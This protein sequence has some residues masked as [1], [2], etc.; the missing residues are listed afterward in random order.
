MI[1]T[2]VGADLSQ[3]SMKEFP[4]FRL[5][6]VNQCLWRHS[7]GADEQRILLTPKAF[8]MLRYL[9]EHAGRPVT[10]DELL[11]ALWPDTF[12]QPEVLKSHIRDIRSALED[13]P[14]DARFIE[15]LPRRGYRF[16][17]PVKDESGKTDLEA[18]SPA[19]KLVG[20]STELDQL[21]VSLRRAGR[22]ERQL[23]FVTGEPGIGKTALVDQF[24]RQAAA[25]TSGLR[26]ARGQCVEGFGG[27]EPYYPMLEA[28]GQLCHGTAADSV[29]QVLA[30]QA[31]TWLVQ[32]PALVKREQRERLQREIIGATRER[33]LRE[34]SDALETITAE[35]PLL[36]V[37][38]D[39]HWVAPSTVDLISVLARRRQPAKLLLV[40]TY[41][42]VDVMLAEHPLKG[43][44]QDLLIH[45]LC[46][47]IALE[48]LDEAD[49]E[50]YLAAES[51]GAAVPAGLAGLLYRHSEG[52]PLF[53]VA[54]LNHLCDRGVIALED[55]SWHLRVPLEKIDVEA[56]ETLRQM[57]ELRIERLSP[58]ERRVLEIASVIRRYPLSV[59]IGAAVSNLQPDT[60][61]ELLEGLARRH[62]IIRPAGFR[63]YKT[64]TSPCYE[65][66]HVLYCEVIYSRIGL[67]RRRKL[68]KSVAETAEVLVV[69][70]EADVIAGF[71][72]QFEE[73]GDW[74][75]AVKYLLSAADTAGRRFEPRQ[76][77]AIL[78]H[79]R[80]LVSKIPEA[81]RAESEI[82]ILLKLA[83]IYAASFDSRVVETY[84]TLAER[85]VH[86]RLADV[87]VRALLEMA[88]PL[89]NYSSVDQY[90]RALDRVDAKLR[91]GEGDALKRAA[92]RALYLCRRIG[93]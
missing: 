62:Q 83:T 58:D 66:V 86:Y 50:E 47:E 33:M 81:E 80:E 16:I 68:H 36:L 85:A 71:A 42:P 77:A 61:E 44:K 7:D 45:H 22:G 38:S 56:P 74:P 57:I 15:T 4:P 25:D 23:V 92:V 67:A 20:R 93:A 19:S 54:A 27:Q 76:A 52:N 3:R 39:V 14:K 73:G 75:R 51:G 89:A 30:A 29:V 49:I 37:F 69:S 78:E 1:E 84:E 63:D 87:E 10:Q 17:A 60:V 32:F 72:Y 70:R 59:T 13:D 24:E 8:A 9:V 53:M 6:L 34:I 88:I 90:L 40:G 12:V 91:S 2:H 18:E 43:L 65:F 48:P 46:H 41:R 35:S 28:L 31:P 5:D 64:G 26:I 55:G 21:R 11:D 79:A 82:Q